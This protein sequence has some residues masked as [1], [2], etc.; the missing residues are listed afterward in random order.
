MKNF[1]RLGLFIISWLSII[2]LPK[3]SFKRYL[4]VANLAISLPL[5]ITLL[6]FPY[7]LWVVEKDGINMKEKILNDLSIILGPF[8]CGTLWY[9]I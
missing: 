9:F 5:I 6:S 7:K 3:S 1:I 2:S 8:F 4:P